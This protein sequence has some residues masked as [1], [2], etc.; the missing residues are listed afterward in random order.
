MMH[1]CFCQSSTYLYESDVFLSI[2]Q[3]NAE[4]EKET[5]P[6]PSG[7]HIVSSHYTESLNTLYTVD[8][9]SQMSFTG[10]IVAHISLVLY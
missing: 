6:W 9:Y 10:F 2:L 8:T 1:R 3:G 7:E 5:P 4:L